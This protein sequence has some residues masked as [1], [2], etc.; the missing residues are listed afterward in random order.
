MHAAHQFKASMFSITHREAQTS[1]GDLLGWSSHDRLGIVVNSPLG[2]L[3]AGLLTLT[4]AT[5]FYDL[6]RKRRM[7]PLYPPIFLFHVGRRRGFYGELD[8]WPDRKEIATPADATEV[9]RAINAVGITHLVVPDGPA[10][11]V[12]HRYKEPEEARDRLRRC[13]V[14]SPDGQVT[15]A[16]VRISTTT[17]PVIENLERV[18]HPVATLEMRER[19]IAETP[20][21]RADTPLGRDTR[22]YCAQWRE[23]ID[24]VDLRDPAV[25]RIQARIEAA[26]AQEYLQ[27]SLRSI[28]SKEALD[29]L[30]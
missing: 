28:D 19:T 24:E 18:A 10:K 29:L 6:D 25:L 27:E 22:H 17:R 14:Y 20:R 13:Y 30:N 15:D 4:V 23:R 12:V 21:L 5:A 1:A 3:G 9:L 16:D 2:A 7:R 8:F 26:L 11:S